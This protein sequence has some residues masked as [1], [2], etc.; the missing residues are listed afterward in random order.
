MELLSRLGKYN[1]LSGILLQNSISISA[2]RLNDYSFQ[3]KKQI[4][5]YTGLKT[6]FPEGGFDV[7]VD[8]KRGNASI[9]DLS[10]LYIA[11]KQDLS[12]VL[13]DEDQH[14]SVLAKA[15]RVVSINFDE[16]IRRTVK[17]QHMIQIYNLIKRAA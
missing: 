13:S 10:S 7:W 2:I 11:Q 9:G 3:L 15:A 17:D 6:E 14:L 16:F 12:I 1:I 8:G 5:I 4:Q